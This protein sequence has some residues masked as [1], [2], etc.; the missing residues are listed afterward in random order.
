MPS[1]QEKCKDFEIQL[2]FCS[3]KANLDEKAIAPKVACTLGQR[4]NGG[5]QGLAGTRSLPKGQDLP[6]QTLW[7][8][9]ERQDGAEREGL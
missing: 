5:G 3:Q 1:T 9:G 4:R 6:G 8:T 7:A 2:S